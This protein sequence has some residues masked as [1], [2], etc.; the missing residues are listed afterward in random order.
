MSPLRIIPCLDVRDGRV[1]KGVQFQ[2][3]RDLGDP[4]TLAR[5][6]QNQGAHEL[7]LLDISATSEARNTRLETIQRV[8]QN[9]SIPLTAGGG[10]RT[11]DDAKRLLDAGAARISIATAAVS[12]PGFIDELS[13]QFGSDK[14]VIAVDVRQR[15]P[16]LDAHDDNPA[17]EVLVAGGKKQTDLDPIPWLIEIASRGAGEILLTSWDRDGTRQGF[18]LNLLSAAARSTTI[19]IIASGGAANAEHFAQA[20]HAGA[21]AVLAASIFHDGDY[22]VEKLRAQITQLGQSHQ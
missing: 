9:I 8:C 10:V 1:V 14:I 18:D 16:A 11:L 2:G 19:P 6:Y 7:V 4:V 12:R 3:L 22:T 13:A 20:F 5:L 17:W 21:H 15:P